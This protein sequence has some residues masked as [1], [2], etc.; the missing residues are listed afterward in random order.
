MND[1]ERLVNEH[2]SALA[3]SLLSAA[4]DEEPPPSLLAHTL[5]SAGLA[6]A[7]AAAEG[8][9]AGLGSTPSK[10]VAFGG[11]ATSGSVPAAATTASAGI[12]GATLKVVGVAALGGTI[13]ASAA[14]ELAPARPELAR[15]S[16]ATAKAHVAEAPVSSV[17]GTAHADAAPPAATSSTFSQ[18]RRHRSAAQRS[19]ADTRLREEAR[20]IDEARA[21]LAAGDTAGTLRALE[22]H[23]QSFARPLF[24]PEALFLRMQ[25]LR[26]QG[27]GSAAR[28]VGER[29]LSKSPNGP[30]A[31]SVRAF[32]RTEQR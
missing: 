7:V 3:R 16:V 21:A 29:L 23:R 17:E 31:A 13:A 6:G 28:R 15:A 19:P 32:L 18:G 22:A 10:A 20:L 26:L 24:E 27:Q 5:A 9:G 4:T 11:K 14:F 12:W 30:H 8:V 25:A 2:P 1:P